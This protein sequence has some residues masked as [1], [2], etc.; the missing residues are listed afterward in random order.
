MK[1][2]I[3]SVI[4][5]L[6]FAACTA[7]LVP[8]GVPQWYGH[9]WTEFKGFVQADEAFLFLAKD[10]NITPRFPALLYRGADSSLYYWNMAKWNKV[11]QGAGT[12][13]EADPT[14]QAHI[15]AITLQQLS[16][17]DQAYSKRI[18][19]MTY[20]T[21]DK[22]L[23]IVL[24]DGQQISDTINFNVINLSSSSSASSI[25]VTPSG[26]GTPIQLNG[27]SSLSAG[28]LVAADKVKYD[29]KYDS[30]NIQNDSI[31]RKYRAGVI[32]DRDTIRFPLV[33]GSETK[34]Q[35]GSGISVSGTGTTSNP[36][37]VTATGSS[38]GSVGY[39]FT[40]AV[41]VNDANYTITTDS[42]SIAIH[43]SL[44]TAD[45]TVTLPPPASNVGRI[46][47]IKHGGNGIYRVLFS[48]PVRQSATITYDS[49]SQ[50]GE[51][52]LMSDNTQ[53]VVKSR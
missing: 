27:A 52:M 40:N 51:V 25:I 15:K 43:Y 37:I 46:I 35:A 22:V 16:N 20:N 53:W 7:Q 24:A 1:R 30:V 5:V 26:G 13:V 17:W 12:G 47:W 23:S 45:R 21:T 8:T 28:L 14:V 9:K 44:L 34:V 50:D 49:L 32:I 42:A 4:T 3:L 41:T 36:Y 10:T 18:A 38:T 2:F 6:C 11:G 33:D 31:L 29:A 39:S 19:S 48:S